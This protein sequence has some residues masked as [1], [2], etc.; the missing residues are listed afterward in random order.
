I[1]AFM[2]VVGGT[3]GAATVSYTLEDMLRLPSLIMR[4]FKSPPDRRQALVGEIVALAELARRDGL[5]A[6]E[7]QELDDPFL[8]RATMLVVDGTDPEVVREILERDVDAMA[9]R[10]AH[11]YGIFTVM[12]GYAPTMGIVGTVM[13]LIHVLSNLSDP[14]ALGPA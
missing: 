4:A 9:E 12:G 1:T 7:D 10:H 14:D 5:L 11:S 8:K 3:I 13:G 6:L 2:I